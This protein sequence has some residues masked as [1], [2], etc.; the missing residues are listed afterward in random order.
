MIVTDITNA[1]LIRLIIVLT[2]E[3]TQI[4]VLLLLGEV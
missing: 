1:H 3:D 2:L 4:I